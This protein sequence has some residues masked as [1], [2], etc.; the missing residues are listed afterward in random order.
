MFRIRF[1]PAIKTL[2]LVVIFIL[3]IR[4]RFSQISNFNENWSS[5]FGDQIKLII[6]PTYKI[7]PTEYS[8]LSLSR[9]FLGGIQSH[10]SATHCLDFTTLNI[11][12]TSGVHKAAVSV[13]YDCTGGY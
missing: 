6:V 1:L 5:F 2:P 11:P 13:N 9:A 10:Y 7:P 12:K 4:L 8:A 3:I